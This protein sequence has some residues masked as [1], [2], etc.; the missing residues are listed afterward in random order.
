MVG[1]HNFIL[2]AAILWGTTGTAQAFAPNG[3]SP[4][5]IGTM[6]LVVGGGALMAFAFVRG[7]LHVGQHWPWI[8][9]GLATISIAAY[10][11]FFFTGIARTGVAVG[12]IVA[13]GS[14]PIFAGLFD[15]LVQRKLPEMRWFLSTPVAILGC[16]LIIL[17]DSEVQIDLIGFSLTLLAGM[18][19]AIYAL[20]TK[21]LLLNHL[22][23]VVL[24]VVFT[25]SALLLSPIL[26]KTD[27]QWLAR[28]D[29]LA[30]ILHLGLI[31]TATAYL[32]FSRGLISVPVANA[33]TLS[34]SEPVTAGILGVVL[35]RE[36]LSITMIAG[37]VFVIS[38]ML[39]LS[40]RK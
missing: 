13:I 37:I 18:A 39:I 25:A 36:Q 33:V 35:L 31:A 10:Q 8:P 27:L 21:R 24:A 26:I 5:A 19:Y 12:T 2:A 9:F 14:S 23:E 4:S 6:R 11:L 40:I 28:P 34:L 17:P 38:G 32:L 30:I 1:G 29:G 22:P 20:T 3:A 16:I 7:E 15:Y